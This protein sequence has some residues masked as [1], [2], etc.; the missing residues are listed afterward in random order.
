MARPLI[1]RPESVRFIEL[2]ES[3]GVEPERRLRQ[4][5]AMPRKGNEPP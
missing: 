2:V 3:H 5:S 4:R 1:A